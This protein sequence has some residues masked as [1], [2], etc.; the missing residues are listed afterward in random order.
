MKAAS[1]PGEQG[2]QGEPFRIL[3]LGAGQVNLRGSDDLQRSDLDLEAPGG[4]LGLAA[5]VPRSRTTDSW[6]S[7]APPS[8]AGPEAIRSISSC[9]SPGD[10]SPSLP[11]GPV[12]HS[13]RTAGM[14]VL[15]V[16]TDPQEVRKDPGNLPVAS[17]CRLPQLPV[18]GHWVRT[19]K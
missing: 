12:N 15:A 2:L 14:P 8:R 9:S 10:I 11:L 17:T 1:T 13:Q 18:V 4:A 3:V 16:I 5:T 6:V 19:V 7:R